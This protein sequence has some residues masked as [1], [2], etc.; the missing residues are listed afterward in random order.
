M[1]GSAAMSHGGIWVPSTRGSLGLLLQH[2]Q[3][4]WLILAAV[5]EISADG[6]AFPMWV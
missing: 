5:A 6:T 1:K 4:A 2:Q 3:D